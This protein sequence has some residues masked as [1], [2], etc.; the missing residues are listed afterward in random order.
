MYRVPVIGSIQ[1]NNTFFN[2]ITGKAANNS[3]YKMFD[4][5]FFSFVFSF[6]HPGP[7][8]AVSQ[9]EIQGLYAIYTVQVLITEHANVTFPSFRTIYPFEMSCK[10]MVTFKREHTK[11][12]RP[13]LNK[14]KHI[15][16][17]NEIK[18][19]SYGLRLVHSHRHR[20]WVPL[21]IFFFITCT[22]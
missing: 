7:L 10:A 11:F 13:T 6:W 19:T 1:I 4:V 2:K 5:F 3:F 17:E 15:K 9:H 16:K 8:N 20:H 21:Y 18:V 12:H 14:V 22:V